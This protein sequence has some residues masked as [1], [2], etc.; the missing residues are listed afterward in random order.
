MRKLRFTQSRFNTGNSSLFPMFSLIAAFFLSFAVSNTAN[1]QCAMTCNDDVNISLSGPDQNC[2]VVITPDMVLESPESC[3]G[4]YTII[5]TTPT[6]GNVPTS[7][8]VNETYINQILTYQ[9]IDGDSNNSC[10]GQVLIE[11]K[12]GPSID[13]TDRT[14][15]CVEDTNPTGDMMPT[16][17]DCSGGM[18]TMA[19]DYFD[20]VIDGACGDSYSAII[21]RTWVASDMMGNVTS[22]TQTITVERVSLIDFTPSCP[23]NVTLQCSMNNPPD[24]DP[25]NTGYPFFTIDGIDYDIVPGAD[26]FCELASSYADET[27]DLCGGGTKILRTW[28]VYDWCV[29]TDTDENPYT[30]IQVIQTEDN[31]APVV[32]CPATIEANTVTSACLST[33]ILPAPLSVE[34]GCSSV[35][36]FVITPQ[37]IKQ[38]GDPITLSVGVHT[39]TYVAT[40][41]CG[42]SS[43]CTATVNVNDNTAPVAVCDEFTIVAL[44]GD[45][46]ALISAMVF[47]DGSE[48]NCEIDRFEARRMGLDCAGNEDVFDEYVE[49]CCE[50]TEENVMV[51]FRV[52]DQYDNYNECMIEVEVQDKL[53]PNIVC[54]PDKTIECEGANININ[55]LTEHGEAIGTDNCETPVITE[56]L[57]DLRTTCGTG[58]LNRIFTATD[59]AGRTAECIQTL[60]IFNSNPF[61][62]ATVSWPSDYETFECGASVEPEDLPLEPLNFRQPV[63][64]S[65]TCDL[66][67]VTYEDTYLPINPPACYK[68]L[69]KWIVIDWCQYDPNQET[70]SGYGEWTQ[71]IK[72]SDN[73]APVFD[74]P[75]ELVITS[76]EQDCGSAPVSFAPFMAQ[77][78][79]NNVDF[80]F[81]IDL[82]TDGSVDV[83]G[84]GNDISGTYPFGM[85]NVKIIAS[86]G[87]GNVGVCEFPLTILDGKKPT[88]I[89]VNGIS[90]ELMP[91][92]EGGMIEVAADLM[93]Y[94]SLDN[95]TEQED[96]ILE[97]NPYMFDCNDVGTNVVTLTVTDEAGNSDY[98]ET[99]IIVQDNM[100]LCTDGVGGDQTIAG[101]VMS[102]EGN[103]MS[104]VNVAISGNGPTANPSL[105]NEAGEFEFIELQSGYDYT[106]QPSMNADFMNGITTFDLVLIRR[107][108]LGLELLD[109]PYKMIAADANKSSS[110]TTS[111]VVVLR[112]MILGLDEVF[113]N[114]N[115]S[116]RFVDANYNFTNPANPWEEGF[117]EVYSINNLEEDMMSVD[118]TAVKVGDVNGTAIFNFNQEA[119]ERSSGIL[120]IETD[121]R[122]LNAGEVYE[123]AMQMP[124]YENVIGYQF[125]LE[126]DTDA[127]EFVNVTPEANSDM[128]AANFGLNNTDK[129]IILVSRDKAE[130]T[131]NTNTLFTITFKAKNN[132][133]LF[134]AINIDR[135]S[136]NAEAYTSGETI[137]IMDLELNFND[138][139]TAFELYQNTPNPF[140]ASTSINFNLPTA[141][142]ATLTVFDLDGKVLTSVKGDFEKGYNAIEINKSDLNAAGVL[143]YQLE[144]AS[145]TATRKMVV[146][147]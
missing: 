138:A 63:F 85:H 47:D 129:G 94:G 36:V 115:T 131:H 44:T 97:L 51:V 107:H 116:Y 127:L 20:S 93:D 90:I 41:Q 49:F 32:V 30:C 123:V 6:G 95:C 1:A 124:D 100:N 57:D 122:I 58:I 55:D 26:N 103:A 50:D 118:F 39:L 31:E 130:N 15:Y 11:D 104:G 128:T 87:C 23:A 45:G 52:F 91:M 42:N 106:V 113:P 114:D 3:V 8:M 54:P 48:D 46:S 9:V 109:S 146:I 88:P 117:P 10:W 110:V 99:Y 142:T 21:N 112:R 2:E 72:V 86:D 19:V 16:I 27:F 77:D 12:L 60:T 133:T 81:E 17:E 37:G 98:C 67:A 76:Q 56:E 65:N 13:C 5:L 61:D 35:E 132:T 143:L 71:I 125:G 14:V 89:C 73:E 25:S 4:P 126:F 84:N 102:E 70:P 33:I 64:S 68:I 134:D 145:H 74:C 24:T 7:P 119:D 105:T 22:C 28:T 140:T 111:D 59:G 147:D 83:F 92:G 78:C 121:N 75:E 141:G 34:D 66:I 43:S 108:V 40:D 82:D 79:S 29:S 101:G 135:E 120:N 144:T 62:I 139:T 69:R 80:S 136:L 96:L 18:S 137:E 38:V 53:D